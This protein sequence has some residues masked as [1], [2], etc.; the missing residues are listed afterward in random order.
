MR[1]LLLAG[2]LVVCGGCFEQPSPV[3]STQQRVEDVLKDTAD[4]LELGAQV[5]DLVERQQTRGAQR[6]VCHH[7]SLQAVFVG[8]LFI[9]G[10]AIVVGRRA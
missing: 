4:D 3:F 2:L 8:A 9:V 1:A 7:Y 10:F 5:R 6:A